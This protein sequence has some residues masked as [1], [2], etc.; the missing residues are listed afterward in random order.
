MADDS[1]VILFHF[2]ELGG[3]VISCPGRFVIEISRGGYPRKG[4]NKWQIIQEG[5]KGGN[6]SETCRAAQHCSEPVLWLEG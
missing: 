2:T 5:L 1:R 6:L 3:K 4:S